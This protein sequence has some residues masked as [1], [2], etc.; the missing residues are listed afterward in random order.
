MNTHSIPFLWITGDCENI[1]ELVHAVKKSGSD[2]FCVESRICEDFCGAKWWSIMDRVMRTAKELQMK[3]WLLDDKSYPTGYANGAVKAH[4]E[5]KSVQIRCDN[6]D[7]A[8][9]LKNARLLLNSAEDEQNG[10]RILHVYLAK[11]DGKEHILDCHEITQAVCGNFVALPELPQ[12]NYRIITLKRTTEC[13][14]G[15]AC[16]I[17]MLSP[18]AVDLLIDAVYEPHYRRYCIERKEYAGVFSGFFSDEPRLY[19]GRSF[20]YRIRQNA[21]EMQ[22]GIQGLAYPYCDTLEERL[23]GKLPDYRSEFLLSLWYEGGARCAEVRC[24]YMELITDLYAENFSGKLSAWCHARGLTYTGHIIEDMGAHTRTMCSAGHYFKSMRGAD[25]AGVDVVLHQIKPYFNGCRHVAPIEGGFADPLFFDCVLAKLA[26]SCAHLDPEKQG[27]ALC[28]IFG[29]YGW[30][31]SVREMLYLVNH[32]TV[33]GINHFIPH[34]FSPVFP[35]ADCPP[36]FYANGHN[37]AYGAYCTLNGYIQKVS[38]LF[39]GGEADIRVAVLY[40]AEAEWSG[41]AYM[42]VDVVCKTLMENQIDFDI[43]PYY[44][45][46][47]AYEAIIVPYAEFLPEQVRGKLASLKKT[48]IFEIANRGDPVPVGEL[49]DCR[50]LRFTEPQPFLRV[51]RYFKNERE[52]YLIHNESPVHVS[53]CALFDGGTSYTAL[54]FLNEREINGAIVNG[55]ARLSIGG[56][57]ALILRIDQ[58][59]VEVSSN[60]SQYGAVEFESCELYDTNGERVSQSRVFDTENLTGENVDF[61]GTAVLTGCARLNKGSVLCAEY[62]GEELKLTAGGKTF[63]R[64]ASPAYFDLG[65]LSGKQSIRM[66]ITTTLAPLIKD[67]LSKYSPIKPVAVY[68]A[69][70]FL[71]G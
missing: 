13:G 51:M 22:V 28:E 14:E 49:Q 10:D 56:G 68:G 32:M 35:H 42:P 1:E 26:S 33:R 12:G 11:I 67:E 9:P 20:P 54:D 3:V 62:D 40:H 63:S 59:E 4:P 45:L 24:A 48:R 47:E 37:P 66:E 44:A 53:A 38:E 5:H 60:F 27:R 50:S 41:K 17:D 16:R 69:K 29:A 58:T 39:S 7:I 15:S 19:N 71:K 64:I 36:H 8:G 6:V 55:E 25:Y 23:R 65:E 70:L 34:S 57:E 2:M 31:M 46:S 43:V 30:A 21:Y 61:S 52:Y 18:Q